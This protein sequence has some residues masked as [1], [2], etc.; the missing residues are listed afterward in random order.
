[1]ITP[2]AFRKFKE[3]PMLE[4]RLWPGLRKGSTH[5]NTGMY[6][7]RLPLCAVSQPFPTASPGN[8]DS[9]FLHFW[10]NCPLRLPRAKT[11][12]C[13][14]PRRA[15]TCGRAN[16]RPC[17]TNLFALSDFILFLLG[18]LE[19]EGIV[20]IK[21]VILARQP[22]SFASLARTAALTCKSLSWNCGISSADIGSAALSS[23]SSS[24]GGERD[25]RG[26]LSKPH[27][28]QKVVSPF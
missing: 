20:Q 18:R 9:S 6:S 24:R 3:W 21:A 22:N 17:L 19:E 5:G 13:L 15:K 25:I 16:L 12:I 27:L 11:V 28:F 14:G 23:V 26:E 2:H 10:G 8:E 4:K 7:D 1:M